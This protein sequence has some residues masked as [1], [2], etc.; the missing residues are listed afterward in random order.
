M[1]GEGGWETEGESDRWK[2]FSFI[3]GLVLNTSTECI[4]F[5]IFIAKTILFRVFLIV[6]EGMRVAVI[7]FIDAQSEG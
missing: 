1:L 6:F 4:Y 5:C 7:F 3:L 2:N